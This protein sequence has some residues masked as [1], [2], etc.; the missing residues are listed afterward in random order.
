M[1]SQQFHAQQSQLLK[2][3]FARLTGVDSSV[4]SQGGVTVTTRPEPSYWPFVAMI[5]G[6]GNGAVA[7]FAGDFADW[8]RQHAPRDV[9]PAAYTAIALAA[10]ATRRGQSI[11][12][13]PAMLG[14]A[15]AHEPQ[16]SEPPQGFELRRVDNAW[17]NEWQARDMFRNALGGPEQEH[18]RFRNQFAH[19]L[20]AD[21]QPVAAAG[22]YDSAGPLEIG[23]DVTP[24]MRGR[25]LA[26]IVVRATAREIVDAGRTPYYGCTVTNVASQRTALASGFLPACWLSLA[27]PAG[28]G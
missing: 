20:F 8:A 9:E 14:W 19:V 2:E 16:P 13:M 24:K 1:E 15:L 23:V 11:E 7:C 12:P 18:R 3:S 26:P 17:M 4:F 28:M 25:Q 21:G 5:V 22:A 6:F 27:M 10:E